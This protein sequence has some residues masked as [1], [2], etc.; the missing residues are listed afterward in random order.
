MLSVVLFDCPGWTDEDYRTWSTQMAASGEILCLPTSWRGEI[1]L[2][3]AFVNPATESSDVISVLAG[4]RN[5]S[6]GRTQ[7]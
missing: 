2:R 4:I 3:L 7:T 1:A 6:A 5:W